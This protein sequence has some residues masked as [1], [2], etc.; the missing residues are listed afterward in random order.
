M[1][2]DIRAL[3]LEAITNL[4]R[5]LSSLCDIKCRV[6]EETRI[7]EWRTWRISS[8]PSVKLDILD[9]LERYVKVLHNIPKYIILNP[10]MG[11]YL[12]GFNVE[13]I[14]ILYDKGVPA[15]E[16]WMGLISTGK[17]TRNWKAGLAAYE[18]AHRSHDI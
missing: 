11:M 18:E 16:L 6:Q 14:E 12:I 3:K 9:G 13:D 17:A 7:T 1:A 8:I 5:T 4:C 10:K 15:Y 2:L